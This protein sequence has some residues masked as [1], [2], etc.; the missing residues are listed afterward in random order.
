MGNCFVAGVDGCQAGWVW[1]KLYD[2]GET[3]S[4]LVDLV[5]VLKRRPDGLR[6]QPDTRCDSPRNPIER[7]LPRGSFCR[8]EYGNSRRLL[9][10]VQFDL[11]RGLMPTTLGLKGPPDTGDSGSPNPIGGLRRIR[12]R[13]VAIGI[14]VDGP[15]LLAFFHPC[16]HPGLTLLFCIRLFSSRFQNKPHVNPL[17]CRFQ[18]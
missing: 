12:C 5:D 13:E 10:V 16:F 11:H 8:A 15:F 7:M 18:T 2:S 1:F 14:F 3:E 9:V 6:A 17:R 4:A